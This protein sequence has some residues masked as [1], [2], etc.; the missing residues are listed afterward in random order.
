[1]SNKDSR[2][3][4]NALMNL[5]SLV[6]NTMIEIEKNLLLTLPKVLKDDPDANVRRLA[7]RL[8]ELLNYHASF[9]Y[10]TKYN[11]KILP[12]AIEI[13]SHDDNKEVKKQALSASVATG[14]KRVIKVM[15]QMID[16]LSEDEYKTVFTDDIWSALGNGGLGPRFRS[17]LFKE[18]VSTTNEETRQRIEAITQSRNLG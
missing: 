2:V 1:M 7:L 15:V 14:D 3:R 17:E 11:K 4:I 10:K 8:Y 16:S 18:F 13:V 6:F 5:T 12:L 9:S